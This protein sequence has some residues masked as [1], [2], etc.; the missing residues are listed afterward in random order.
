M[1]DVFNPSSDSNPKAFSDPGGLLVIDVDEQGR[2]TGGFAGDCEL[3]RDLGAARLPRASDHLP[4]LLDP[5]F[6]RAL[7]HALAD[8]KSSHQTVVQIV[9]GNRAESR[10]FIELTVAVRLDHGAASPDRYCITIR[11]AVANVTQLRKLNRLAQIAATTSNLVVVTDA[12]RRIEWVNASFTRVSGYTLEEAQ[13]RSPGE[14]LQFAGT[15]ATTIRQIR[16]ALDARQPVKA[17][18]LNRSKGGREYWLHLDIQPIFDSRGQLDGFLAIQ[19]DITEERLNALRLEQLAKQAE[20]AHSTLQAA[21]AGLPSGFALFDAEDRLV[22]CN[23]QYRT[24]HPKATAVL[25]PGT[26]LER[27]LREEVSQGEYPICHG[28]TEKWLTENLDALQA[29]N[30][31]T[32]EVELSDGR[33]VRSVKRCIPTGGRIGLRSDIT[34]LKQAE[35]SAV[36]QRAAAMDASHDGIAITDTSG[37]LVYVN[38]AMLRASSHASADHWIGRAWEELFHPDDRASLNENSRIALATTGHWRGQL[39]SQSCAGHAR[40]HEVALTRAP[41]GSLVL[42]SRDISDRLRLEAERN[43]LHDLVVFERVAHE[44]RLERALIETKRLHERDK[45][46][47]ED[48]ELLLRALQSLSAA[49][50]LAD[51]PLHL[52]N[53]LGETLNTRCVALISKDETEPPLCLDEPVWWHE[54]AKHAAIVDYLAARPRRLIRDLAAL[55]LDVAFVSSWPH[56]KLSWMLAARLQPVRSTHLLVI[57]GCEGTYVDH[58]KTRLF[59][60]FVP[61]VGEALRR[62]DDHLR[63][64]KLE[65]DLQQ[66]HKMESLGT[67]AGGIAHEI[68][69]PM[70]FIS[71]NLHFLRDAFCEL[72]A[73]YR[74]HRPDTIAADGAPD[75]A[76]ILQEIPLAIEQSIAGSRRVAE[77][78]EAVRTFAYPELAQ[79][80]RIQLREMLEHCLVI[81]RTAWKHD[82]AVS[83]D[84][85]KE[86]PA[87]KGSPGQISQVF[88]NLT[89]NACD[90]ARMAKDGAG[91]IVRL[92]L[93]STVDCVIVH[94]D[95]NGPG[96]PG[97]LRDRIFDPFFTTKGIGKGTGQGLGISR[98]IVERHGGRIDLG[99]SPLG[100]ARFSVTLPIECAVVGEMPAFEGN[101]FRP[102][103]G[104]SAAF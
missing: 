6:E 81:T 90:A 5:D 10:V 42:I 91:G 4:S 77:L 18:I 84:C 2:C 33:W 64:R 85:P 7:K 35:R 98:S 50:S 100:G 19:S 28:Q 47:R 102:G 61:L 17:T 60:R 75:L 45:Q 37:R 69:T 51:G 63:A 41:D 48:S 38:P 29:N 97:V 43:H 78:V 80:E 13:G 30:E 56:G 72:V 14:L 16:R 22:F 23:D 12:S 74:T 93:D 55:S 27:I 54:F 95:D 67:L 71:D 73:A 20:L 65:R 11:D 68:N 66:A 86:V 101:T 40:E 70:Q 52:L 34:S 46:L 79:I 62:R 104:A 82:V 99:D 24:L 26:T 57:G 36:L 89:T 9:S 3:L 8:C 1:K 83:L 92:S 53:Q 58:G 87:I 39:R 15:D 94:I 21:V 76:Y 59:S 103:A 44:A 88:I 25:Q 31:W 96:V 49:E 32:Q